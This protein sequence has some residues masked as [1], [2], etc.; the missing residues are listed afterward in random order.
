MSGPVR[1]RNIS[2]LDDGQDAAP[3]DE[4]RQGDEYDPSRTIGA[5]LA[6]P[7]TRS[8][9]IPREIDPRGLFADYRRSA[10]YDLSGSVKSKAI[11]A[12][13]DAAAEAN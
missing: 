13:H 7:A 11:V 8:F 1:A 10:L 2:R 6:S 12:Q 3:L 5:T 9:Q 4:P